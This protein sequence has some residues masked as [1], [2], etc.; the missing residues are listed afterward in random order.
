MSLKSKE[1]WPSIIVCDTEFFF[2]IE[3]GSLI[4]GELSVQSTSCTNLDRSAALE[5]THIFY[6]EIVVNHNYDLYF[7]Q[8]KVP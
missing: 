2:K 8:N 6:I 3:Q 1:K 4:A 5:I 7:L